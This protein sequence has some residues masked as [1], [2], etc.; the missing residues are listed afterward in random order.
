MFE[1]LSRGAVGGRDEDGVAPAQEKWTA[2]GA[3]LADQSSPTLIAGWP[4]LL[5]LVLGI[6]AM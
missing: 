1:T 6:G 2:I 5:A 4:A 3:W